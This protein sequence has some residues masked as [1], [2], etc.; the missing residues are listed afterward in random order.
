MAIKHY[1]HELCCVA[2]N[3][4]DIKQIEATCLLFVECLSV[5]HYVVCSLHLKLFIT[6]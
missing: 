1:M 6:L 4:L 5:L 3:Y 2:H